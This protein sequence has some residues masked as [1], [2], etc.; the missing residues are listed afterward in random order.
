M[1]F[2]NNVK[3]QWIYTPMTANRNYH[4]S[5]CGN[6]FDWCQQWAQDNLMIFNFD[7][8]EALGFRQNSKFSTTCS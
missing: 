4:A 5:R 8:N 7:K 3:M 1:I 2:P 6:N